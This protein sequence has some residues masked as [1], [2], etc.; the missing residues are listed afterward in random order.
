MKN[1][2]VSYV[3]NTSKNVKHN[4]AIFNGWDADVIIEDIKLAVLWN[5]KWHYEK[6]NKKS[7][8]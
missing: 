6:D 5:G 4:E 1:I 2:F 8:C 3:N 7:F